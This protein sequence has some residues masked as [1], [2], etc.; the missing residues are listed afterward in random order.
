MEAVDDGHRLRLAYLRKHWGTMMHNGDTFA[1][2]VVLARYLRHGTENPG[3]PELSTELLEPYMD[4]VYTM[5]TSQALRRHQHVIALA[6]AP[7]ATTTTGTAAR[8]PRQLQ[9]YAPGSRD[10]G[11]TNNVR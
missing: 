7:S 4:R 11:A 3:S 6:V 10:G 9:E 1:L 5:R 8:Q 2:D